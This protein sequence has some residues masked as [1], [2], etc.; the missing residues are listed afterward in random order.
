MFIYSIEFEYE[1]QLETRFIVRAKNHLEAA[2]KAEKLR[3]KG[4]Q[5]RIIHSFKNEGKET[6]VKLE[7]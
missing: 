7:R 1:Y 4:G 3:T 6:I 2:E 5:N